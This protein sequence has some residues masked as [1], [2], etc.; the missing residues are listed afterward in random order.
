MQ[1]IGETVD[2]PEDDV[3][4]TLA[5]SE[6]LSL[7]RLAKAANDNDVIAGETWNAC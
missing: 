4:I 2:S 3:I 1:V 6:Y 7:V 5:K